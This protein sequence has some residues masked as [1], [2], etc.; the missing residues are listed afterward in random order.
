MEVGLDTTDP[1]QIV[2]RD[3]CWLLRNGLLKNETVLDYFS[4]SPFYDK[5]CNN[6][7]LKMT[8]RFLDESVERTM[9]RMKGIEYVVINSLPPDLFIIRKQNRVAYNEAHAL[10]EYY[11]LRG[12]VYHAPNLESILTNRLVNTLHYLHD[13]FNQHYHNIFWNPS[14]G[15]TSNYPTRSV[16][17]KVDC[18]PDDAFNRIFNAANFKYYQ[19]EYLAINAP[20]EV[21]PVRNNNHSSTKLGSVENPFLVREDSLVE[22]FSQKM[23]INEKGNTAVKPK[24]KREKKQ[25]KKRR[26]REEKDHAAAR[27][28]DQA[29]ITLHYFDKDIEIDFVDSNIFFVIIGKGSM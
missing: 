27:V 22:K 20:P 10:E 28:K 11:I 19:Q 17:H 25:R 18:L 23:F 14:T 13:A 29:E 24:E 12:N 3:S 1:R 4:L 26:S 15:Y 5:R 16:E 6:E 7:L 8:C 21:P 9:R 2:F